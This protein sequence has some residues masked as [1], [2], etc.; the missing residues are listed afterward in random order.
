MKAETALYST[1]KIGVRKRIPYVDWLRGGA[2]L[3]MIQTHT[4]NSFTRPDLR[5]THAYLLSQF[6]GGLAAPLFLFVTGITLAW[7]IER[8][9]S[10]GWSPE[11]R[12][13]DTMKRAAYLMAIALLFRLQLWGF[14]VSLMAWHDLLRVDILN[15]MA[16]A[17]AVMAVVAALPARLRIQG[18]VIAGVLIAAFA[19]LAGLIDWGATP[20]FLRDYFVPSKGNFAFFPVASYIPAGMAAG[21]LIHRTAE[22]GIDALMRWCVLAGLCAI[23]AGEHFSSIPYSLYPHSEF[24]INSPMLILIRTGV[25]LILLA[26]AYLWTTVQAPGRVGLVRQVGMTSLLV[27]WVHIELIYGNELWF[28]KQALTIWQAALAAIAI[29]GLMYWLSRA[30]MRW[31]NVPYLKARWANRA[32]ARAAAT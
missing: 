18:A 23:Y 31:L 1:V 30:R 11:R 24:W 2:V 21:A 6:F 5:Q 26:S 17:T 15:C 28:L 10:K 7:R 25:I 13:A 29:T 27:Y 12:A 3:L 16:L 8:A 20:A 4:F 14:K 19:P 22:E 9:D 32:E